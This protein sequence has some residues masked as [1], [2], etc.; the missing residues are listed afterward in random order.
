MKRVLFLLWLIPLVQIITAQANTKIYTD[1]EVDTKAVFGQGKLSFEEFL[2]YYQKY[3]EEAQNNNISGTVLLDVVVSEK[4]EV[5]STKVVQSAGTVLDNETK[6]LAG[7]MPDFTPAIKDGVAVSSKVLL[8]FT[9][10]NNH[11]SVVKK[12]SESKIKSPL[13]VIDGKIVEKDIQLEAEKI[14]SVRVLK[15]KKAIEKYGERARDGVLI[16]TTK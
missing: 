11:K 3:P 9:Y 14:E 8:A 10:P 1:L 16:F 5:V 4:G 6:R 7:L 12:P 13:Y 15:G 2:R